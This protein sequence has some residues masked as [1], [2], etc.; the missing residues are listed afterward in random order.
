[1]KTL[2]YFTLFL[3]T[4]NTI[5]AQNISRKNS[6][7]NWQQ[8]VS[9]KIDA[10][11]NDMQNSISAFESIIYTNNSPNQLNEIYFHLWPNAYR[12]TQTAFAKQ[13]LENNTIDFYFSKPES[14]G[15]ID[16]LDFKVNGKSVKWALQNDIDICKI[17]LNE[18]L[19]PGNS[20]EITTPFFVKI[21][22]V[23]SR[24]G[25]ENGT[26][27]ITQWYPKPAVYDANGWNTFPYLDQGEF[28]SEFGKFDVRI[29]VPKEYVLAATGVLQNEEEKTWLLDKIENN[30]IA[31]PS[32]FNTKTLR[33]VQDSVHDFA[34]FCDKGF[35]IKKSEVIL[36][37]GKK[38][39]TWIYAKSGLNK[40][41][42]Y[43]NEAIQFYSEKVGEY[44][45][46][47]A[48]V[49]IT[50]LKA[51]GGMEYPTITNCG[52]VDQTTL[53]HEVGHNWFYGILA[54][55]EREH[56]W[57]DESINTY[58]ENRYTDGKKD[59]IN[60]SANTILFSAF[61]FEFKGFGMTK[62]LYNMSARSNFDQAGN[63]H[64]TAY[65]S[66]NY[67][68]I[69]Y[70]KNPLSFNFLQNY[71]GDAQFDA[72]MQSYYEKWKFKHPLPNDFR[73]HAEEFTGK[74]LTWFF[75]ELLST[76]KKVDYKL[77]AY[78]NG[79]LQIKNITGTSVPFS[80]S[81]T[82]GK[83][84]WFDGVKKD[85][86][87]YFQSN[88]KIIL[89][90][91]EKTLEL[92]R[93]NNQIKTKGIFKTCSPTSISFFPK[94]ESSTKKQVFIMPAYGWN[95]YNGNMY[96]A[97]ISNNIFPA[98]K[99]DFT[100]VPLYSSVTNDWNGYASFAK[101]IYPKTT[102][103]RVQIGI[104]IARFAS[105]GIYQREFLDMNNLPYTIEW[106]GNIS[107]EKIDPFI[108]LDFA[109]KSAKSFFSNTLKLRYVMINETELAKNYFENFDENNF[110]FVDITHLFS[111]K[112]VLYPSSVKLNA[113][114]CNINKTSGRVGLEANQSFM[115][116]ANKET[117]DIRFFAGMF[118]SDPGNS[119]NEQRIYFQAGAVSG[120]YDYMYDQAMF[121]RVENN[122]R[123]TFFA[124]Q[125]IN[126]DAGFRN[127]VAIGQSKS[128]LTALNFTVPFPKKMPFGFY[129][130]FV[131]W[132]SPEGYTRTV[133]NGITT[134]VRYSAENKF[135][136]AG[137]IYFRVS[138]NVCEFYFPLFASSDINT[139]WSSNGFE[140]PFERVSFI[141]N[142]NAINPVKFVRNLKF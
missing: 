35:E 4:C 107:Y 18:P 72:M 91:A 78:K 7:T 31:N 118:L 137:G 70:S 105:Q 46:S 112:N 61:N 102:Y 89:D 60:D 128:W 94:L 21:P 5:V 81:D 74:N 49:V 103:R 129:A 92:Y 67:G 27:C 79:N 100:F 59:L 23:F 140:R 47:L 77:S 9:Y 108:E 82:S 32:Q 52:S 96:G 44:P 11:L 93:Q 39:D 101:N 43:V 141:L 2:Y 1:M 130:D 106:N 63:L 114:I 55:N 13:Q 29:S 85:T 121:G 6:Q 110:S 88:N 68:A 30:S 28:Y 111:Y 10:S 33:F 15:F 76:N 40:G 120:T 51:G 116:D 132:E 133:Q 73:N 69:V 124:R 117:L 65:T 98:Q 86:V 14:R 38:V 71:L 99:T 34:W 97:I 24:M 123:E 62:L 17:E 12:N 66:F 83:T 138:K 8:H 84:K 25:V 122:Q 80:I 90:E 134:N 127:F 126:R 64:S 75:D 16:S 53:V 22:S 104:N 36:K 87:I 45:Y 58:Y 139:Y 19:L 115:L 26:Y 95:F 135:S 42:K 56:P 113:Q 50:P 54:N 136:Y 125:I 41:I 3:A 119:T 57:M 109:P 37:S 20:I 48:Q 131:F 142:L